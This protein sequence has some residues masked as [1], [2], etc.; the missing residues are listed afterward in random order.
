MRDVRHHARTLVGISVFSGFVSVGV[1]GA[2]YVFGAYAASSGPIPGALYAAGGMIFATVAMIA[3]VELG[4][5]I[6]PN[7]VSE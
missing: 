1:V 7:E 4:V 3:G 6:M 5:L 2:L